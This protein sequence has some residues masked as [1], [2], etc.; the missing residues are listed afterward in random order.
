MN[1]DFIF[2]HAQNAPTNGWWGD[3]RGTESAKLRYQRE[4]LDQSKKPDH[5]KFLVLKGETSEIRLAALEKWIDVGMK[6][7]DITNTVVDSKDLGTKTRLV[8]LLGPSGKPNPTGLG[9]I[10]NTVRSADISR[11]AVEQII[12]IADRPT[13]GMSDTEKASAKQLGDTALIVLETIALTNSFDAI[14]ILAFKHLVGKDKLKPKSVEGMKNNALS[15]AVK[16][17][18]KALL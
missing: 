13:A 10:A 17:A 4:L 2:H 5:L 6:P 18:A 9:Y 3:M 7:V 14:A 1:L 15:T 12:A 16:R 11:A 8:E